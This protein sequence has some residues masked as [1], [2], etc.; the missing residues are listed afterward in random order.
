MSSYYLKNKDKNLYLKNIDTEK[1]TI[2]F[3]ENVNDAKPYPNG[4][5]FAETELEFAQFHFPQE[6]EILSKMEC[7]YEEDE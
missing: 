5:W 6:E 4:Q 3:T 2:E 7:V 1:E